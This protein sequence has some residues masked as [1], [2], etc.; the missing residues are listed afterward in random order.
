MSY[1]DKLYFQNRILDDTSKICFKNKW[2]Q[3]PT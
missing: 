3:I 2:K 1:S